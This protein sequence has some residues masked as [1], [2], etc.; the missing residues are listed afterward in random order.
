MRELMNLLESAGR[1]PSSEELTAA[2][3][4]HIKT[5][6]EDGRAPNAYEI[7][8]GLCE[9]FAEE[10]VHHFVPR[11]TDQFFTIWA[12][13]LTVDGDGEEWDIPLIEQHWAASK[14][15]H[16]LTWEDVANEIPSHCWIILNGRHYD[17]ECPQGVD[18][19]FE[20]PLLQKGMANLAGKR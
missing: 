6:I 20:L 19:F 9:D 11:E 15:T 4:A 5:Y 1:V 17:A 3:A 13:N 18:N 7:N 14:P 2:I 10:V 12:D 8:N 16:G